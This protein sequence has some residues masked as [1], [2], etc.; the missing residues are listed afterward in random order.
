MSTHHAKVAPPEPVRGLG[1]TWVNRGPAYWRRRTMWS[2]FY[3]LLFAMGAGGSFG[4][5]LGVTAS[6]S[7]VA[8]R[9]A[10]LAVAGCVILA[11]AYFTFRSMRKT[12]Q[13]GQPSRRMSPWAWNITVGGG[14]LLRAFA[15]TLLG[16]LAILFAFFITAGG[17]FVVFLLSLRRELPAEAR[18]RHQLQEWQARHEPTP[19]HHAKGERR[20]HLPPTTS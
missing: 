14:P 16:G 8:F 10:V 13:S 12:E 15:N 19:R 1:L 20:P 18:A 7:P 4:I 3:L 5:L 11:S 17:M 9:V 2:L 6:A